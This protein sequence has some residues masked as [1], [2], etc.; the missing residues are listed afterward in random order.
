VVPDFELFP[1]M[2]VL[3]VGDEAELFLL[4]L[5][6]EVDLQNGGTVFIEVFDHP[7]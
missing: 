5:A 7:T 1:F 4:W 6:V 2:N 3:Q